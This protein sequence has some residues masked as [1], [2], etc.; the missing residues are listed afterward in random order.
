MGIEFVYCEYDP[1]KRINQ[2]DLKGYKRIF[3]I[4]VQNFVLD[5]L[6]S[7]PGV[8]GVG[9]VDVPIPTPTITSFD[10]SADN[11]S[12]NTDVTLSAIFTNGTGIITPGNL[13]I[14]SG[15]LVI[16]RTSYF[17]TSTIV[18]YTL[19]VYDLA[20]VFRLSRQ[21]TITVVPYA[22][23]TITSF[24][25]SVSD[26]QSGST[27]T[28]TSIIGPH[29]SGL[30][31]IAEFD[32]GHPALDVHH[33]ARVRGLPVGI[34]DIPVSPGVAVVFPPSSVSVLLTL[35]VTNDY[36]LT[37]TRSIT[38]TIP[39]SPVPT[40]TPTVPTPIVPTPPSTV[41]VPAISSFSSDLNNL[42]PN[43]NVLLTAIFSNGNGVI[44]PGN[45]SITSGGS[46]LVFP[47][48]TTIYTLTVLN[49]NN[50]YFTTRVYTLTVI[51][52]PSISQFTSTTNNMPPNTTIQLTANFE[53]GTGVITPGNLTITM[54]RS[55]GVDPALT[56][57]YLLTVTNSRGITATREH[58]VTVNNLSTPVID[59]FMWYGTYTPSNSDVTTLAATSQFINLQL[60]GDWQTGTA[61]VSGVFLLGT[62]VPTTTTV[63]TYQLTRGTLLSIGFNRSVSQTIT[64]L[65]TNPD[66]GTATRTVT[67][68]P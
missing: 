52:N 5:P 17:T 6:T 47:S 29:T 23:P 49:P 61:T 67:Y 64:L 22:P 48:V 28:G 68:T 36:G 42:G 12:P 58:T 63:N 55:V 60:V 13:P 39:G 56:T 44:T 53:N 37:V 40:L 65:V 18:T 7:N 11:V 14:A 3:N 33:N 54:G 26:V 10:Q 16:V 20:G 27:I 21:L 2:F 9:G 51:P 38:Y 8:G 4:E 15:G 59:Y 34:I 46:A 25:W 43:A 24:L 32:D 41:V 66:G 45:L 35:E 30:N 57:I 19:S 62:S 50:N 31:F 1:E